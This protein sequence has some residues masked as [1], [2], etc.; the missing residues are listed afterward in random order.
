MNAKIFG[1]KVIF[2]G[3]VQGVCFRAHTKEYADAH[4]IIGYAKNMRN[5]DV[6]CVL[7][8]TSA[9]IEGLIE[10]CYKGQPYAS[11][12][13]HESMSIHPDENVYR[14]FRIY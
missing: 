14:D 8:G 6:E 13:G 2:K 7:F 4:S 9:D 1:K 5:G 3:Q 11:V 12:K 10:Y